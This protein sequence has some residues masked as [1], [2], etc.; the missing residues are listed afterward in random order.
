MSE[1][2]AIQ[3]QAKTSIEVHGV[4]ISNEV[5]TVVDDLIEKLCATTTTTTIITTS[6]TRE[7]PSANNEFYPKPLAHMQSIKALE[8]S[9]IKNDED[10]NSK[11]MSLTTTMTMASD[12]SVNDK[13]T[14]QTTLILSSAST[15]Q[16]QESTPPPSA[17]TTMIIMSK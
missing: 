12:N 1:E 11:H 10:H 8:N 14:P 7:E 13:N 6:T 2:V 5:Q 4:N 15:H 17:A 9:D 16:Q 3:P